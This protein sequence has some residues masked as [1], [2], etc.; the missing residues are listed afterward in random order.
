M[1]V[2]T[3]LIEI[4]T[5]RAAADVYLFTILRASRCERTFKMRES[6]T[7]I[8][9]AYPLTDQPIG[10]S[11]PFMPQARPW[12]IRSTTQRPLDEHESGEIFAA[13]SHPAAQKPVL[14]PISRKT[15]S[16]TENQ[17]FVEQAKY[18]KQDADF[19]KAG[20][21]LRGASLLA[22]SHVRGDIIADL[23][24]SKRGPIPPKDEDNLSKPAMLWLV[25]G[26]FVFP[27]FLL[28][29]VRSS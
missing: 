21:P 26:T 18:L 29:G 7:P 19:R 17:G 24:E 13:N 2:Y 16:V 11:V 4:P 3:V 10:T 22:G 12:N 1:F 15:A 9:S 25:L 27:L 6:E 23:S 20:L 8:R 28:C 14:L 5:P